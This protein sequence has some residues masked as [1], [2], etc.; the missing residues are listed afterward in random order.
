[1]NGIIASIF[2]LSIQAFA[3]YQCGPATTNVVQPLQYFQ[4]ASTSTLSA[5]VYNAR[6][7]NFYQTINGHYEK[8]M[9]TSLFDGALGL[10]LVN[11]KV[12][13]SSAGFLGRFLPS[14][15]LTTGLPV[16]YT[17]GYL[18]TP[19]GGLAEGMYW[20]N[21]SVGTKPGTLAVSLHMNRADALLGAN[22]VH[23]TAAGVGAAQELNTGC[24]L[25]DG[26]YFNPATAIDLS[27]SVFT[28]RSH[29]LT[30]GMRV[31]YHIPSGSYAPAGL[32][33]EG[34]GTPYY[35]RVI[36]PDSFAL[37]RS[38]ADA[39]SDTN[40]LKI[41]GY[42]TGDVHAVLLP[43]QAYPLR[44]NADKLCFSGGRV[45]GDQPYTLE[46]TQY[47]DET[48]HYCNS[49]GALFEGNHSVIE[50][51]R[52][53]QVW[54]GIRTGSANCDL[55][56]GLCS[57]KIRDSWITLATDD[58]IENDSSAGLTV[59]NVLIDGVYSGISNTG[60]SETDPDHS[61]SDPLFM[62]H[63]YMR[64]QPMLRNGVMEHLAPLKLHGHAGKWS[65]DDCVFAIENPNMTNPKR[66]STWITFWSKLAAN[67]PT[68]A[69]KDTYLLYTGG[70][71]LPTGF[72]AIPSCVKVETGQT[73]KNH[74]KTVKAAWITKHA[75]IDHIAGIDPNPMVKI[76]AP[77]NGAVVS[78]S[79]NVVVSASDS[80][81][82]IVKV[83][84][85]KDGVLFSARTTAPFSFVLDTRKLTKGAHKLQ[86][87][88]LDDAGVSIVSASVN[89]TVK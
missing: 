66:K 48:N 37:Y 45:M 59:E 34:P 77:L 68:T 73:A 39:A 76:T 5:P 29:G 53:H 56:P 24:G 7:I 51:L 38:V 16:I 86:A 50:G 32:S 78:Q 46:L 63:V 54:D 8:I 14:K 65:C 33:P 71:T 23:F 89:I 19:I 42:G 75:D 1:M 41:T 15:V 22:P 58:A 88:A 40:R 21:T 85:Q 2:A 10:D 80:G 69:C 43:K 55:T 4:Y 87:V 27:T 9:G 25:R 26:A 82:R 12:I 84:L 70:D 79:I 57:I 72:P 6:G 30:Q 20:V 44:V 62:H 67:D 52:V 35:V 17:P 74:W 36:S 83:E 3:T 11:S 18:G 49:A 81:S 64:L 61:S 28:V 31:G 13:V 60:L 47:L